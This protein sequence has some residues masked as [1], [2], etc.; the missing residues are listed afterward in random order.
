MAK[1]KLTD[2]R[3]H[4]FDTLERL[5]ENELDGEQGKAVAQIAQVIINTAK[6]EIQAR[7]AQI[8]I[9]NGFYQCKSLRLTTHGIPGLSEDSDLK[10][11][12]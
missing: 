7:A 4:L 9:E 2:L 10:E 11:T 3:D 12:A 6:L 1:N 5:K 8:D